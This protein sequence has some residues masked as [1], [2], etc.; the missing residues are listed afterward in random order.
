MTEEIVSVNK[1][2]ARRKAKRAGKR[3]A[4]Y[5]SEQVAAK[6]RAAKGRAKQAGKRAAGVVSRRVASTG[7]AVR[8]R[9]SRAGKAAATRLLDAGIEI[10][11]KQ[12]AALEKLKT[13]F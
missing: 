7:D 13:R 5:V 3:V 4:G 6:G 8:R 2:A 1:E 9:A 12:Q 10:S 11:R